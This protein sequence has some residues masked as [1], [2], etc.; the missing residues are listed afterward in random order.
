MWQRESTLGVLAARAEPCMAL[1]SRLFRG[2]DPWYGDD[3]ILPLDAKRQGLWVAYEPSLLAFERSS[4]RPASIAGARPHDA[5][6]LARNPEPTRGVQPSAPAGAVHRRAVTQTPA[7]GHSLL[8]P[9]GARLGRAVG[10]P[11]PDRGRDCARPA[12]PDWPRR[13]PGMWHTAWTCASRWFRS[14]TASRWTTWA[15]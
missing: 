9:C 6:E 3:V 10:R 5:A 4:E 8:V 11:G 1:R 14:C 2:I 15:S 7:L 13:W 12:V